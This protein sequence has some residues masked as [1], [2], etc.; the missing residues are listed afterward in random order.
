[1]WQVPRPQGPGNCPESVSEV[2]ESLIAFGYVMHRSNPGPG[3]VKG[4]ICP[5]ALADQRSRKP[6]KV[7]L[8]APQ[9]L[10]L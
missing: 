1:M 8:K 4:L 6:L 9:V 10:Q 5:R 3:K 7:F 2:L